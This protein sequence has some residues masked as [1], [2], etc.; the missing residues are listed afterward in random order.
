MPYKTKKTGD[1]EDRAVAALERTWSAIGCDWIAAIAQSEGKNPERFSVKEDE[2][3]EAVSTC[4]FLCGYPETYGN[5]REA[6]AW[7]DAQSTAK[8]DAI[9]AKAFPEGTYGL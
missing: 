8:Q 5:D 1:M 7:L 9:L 6:I 3:R 2:V 4:G